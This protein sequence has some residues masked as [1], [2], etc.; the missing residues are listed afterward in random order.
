MI[1]IQNT[2]IFY[3]RWLFSIDNNY[4]CTVQELNI[5]IREKLVQFIPDDECIMYAKNGLEYWSVAE[6]EIYRQYKISSIHHE[7]F[8]GSELVAQYLSTHCKG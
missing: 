7:Q 6:K 8:P 5:R 2:T 1:V 3:K 4:S